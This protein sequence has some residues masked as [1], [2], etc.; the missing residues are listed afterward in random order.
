MKKNHVQNVGAI[1]HKI[2]SGPELIG[3]N[4]ISF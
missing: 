4:P 1:K 2:L 3:G